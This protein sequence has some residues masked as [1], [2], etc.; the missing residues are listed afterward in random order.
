MTIYR[1][2][3]AWA[4]FNVLFPIITAQSASYNI[5]GK[6]YVECPWGIESAMR[7]CIMHNILGIHN[8]ADVVRRMAD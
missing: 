6:I 2:R 3:C 5:K 1:V 4:E 8:V 7:I